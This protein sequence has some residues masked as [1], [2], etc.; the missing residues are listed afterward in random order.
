MNVFF[1]RVSEE[2]MDFVATTDSDISLSCTQ[3][4]LRT[5]DPQPPR[6]SRSYESHTST[7]LVTEKYLQIDLFLKTRINRSKHLEP[8]HTWLHVPPLHFS[9]LQSKQRGASEK[10]YVRKLK[11]KKNIARYRNWKKYDCCSASQDI[12]VICTLQIHVLDIVFYFFNLCGGTFG[13][14]ATT[15][16]LYQPQMI[17]DGDCEEIGGMKIGGV[18]RSTRRKPAPAPLCPPQIT[19]D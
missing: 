9:Y 11:K 5:S 18:N 4:R 2:V 13:T 16:L 10:L 3:T 8:A 7:F 15:G 6:S 19:H 12:S 17:G 14:A 1:K